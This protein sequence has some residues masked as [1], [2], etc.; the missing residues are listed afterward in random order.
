LWLLLQ[1]LTAFLQLSGFSNVGATAHLGGAAAGF[2][3]WLWWRCRETR[4]LLDA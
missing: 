3:L 1:S 4:P 2:G